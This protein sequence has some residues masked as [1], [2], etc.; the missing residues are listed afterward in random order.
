M[1]DINELRAD[2]GGNPD[3]VRESQRRRH[4]SVDLVEEV[5]ELDRQWVKCRCMNLK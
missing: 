3:K 4:A 1:L 2:K 5:I